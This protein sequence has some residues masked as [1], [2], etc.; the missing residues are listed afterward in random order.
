MT[1]AIIAAKK[2]KIDHKI[3]EY[4]HDTSA[5]SYG[6]EAADKLGVP[7]TRIFKTL[8]INLGN[9]DLAVG[10]V[11]VSALL[12]LKQMAK[13]CGAK[14]AEMADSAVA[15]RSTGYVLGG[16]SPLGQKKRLKT[17]IDASAQD[18]ATIYISAGRRGLD[19]ELSPQNLQQL[20]NASFANISQ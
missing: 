11:P 5:S 6:A 14:K 9:K 2:A 7:E 15:E 20:T 12:N 8:I 16:I 10:V 3:H 18:F 13:A 4:A 1:P 19:L 17:I